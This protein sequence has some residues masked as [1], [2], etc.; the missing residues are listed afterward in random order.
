MTCAVNRGRHHWFPA[1]L[2]MS[3]DIEPQLTIAAVEA[4]EVKLALTIEESLR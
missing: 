3:V 2:D 4:D 1:R